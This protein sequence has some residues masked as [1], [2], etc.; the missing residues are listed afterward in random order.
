MCK[1]WNGWWGLVEASLPQY[2]KWLMW[3]CQHAVAQSGCT[4][5]EQDKGWNADGSMCSF[6]TNTTSYSEVDLAVLVGAV[7]NPQSQL[8]YIVSWSKTVS[9]SAN[10]ERLGYSAYAEDPIKVFLRNTWSS[11]SFVQQ[12]TNCGLGRVIS[13]PRFNIVPL[14]FVFQIRGSY[15]FQWDFE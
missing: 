15:I 3:L 8:Q 7:E 14:Y 13:F 11:L 9:M 12:A 1:L 5:F 10:E 4:K 6:K 2:L